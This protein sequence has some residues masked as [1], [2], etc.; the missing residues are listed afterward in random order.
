MDISAPAVFL[1][2]STIPLAESGYYVI[3][4]AV[5]HEMFIQNGVHSPEDVRS[6]SYGRLREIFGADA[7]LYITVT[8]FGVSYQVV[9][10]VVQA[11]ASARLVDL[12]TGQELWSGQTSVEQS[13]GN[14]I[15]PGGNI[16][17]Q[18]LGMVIEAA[19]TQVINAITNPS[20]GVGKEAN[21]MLLSAQK[22]EKNPMS[23]LYGPYHPGFGK[24]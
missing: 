17:Q 22:P 3:P 11:S 7:A 23:I 2:T 14:S 5:S 6:I 4:V 12:R 19:V 24:D 20:Y 18:L 10:S 8:H 15:M 9:R 13:S 21:Y 1:A 16:G